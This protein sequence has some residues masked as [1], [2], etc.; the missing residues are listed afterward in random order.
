MSGPMMA[1]EA[2]TPWYAVANSSDV[3]SPALLVFPERVAHNVRKMIAIAGGPERLRPHVKTHKL[4]E[5]VRLK[6]GLGIQKF[7]CA[8]IAELEMLGD[9]GVE[10]A[11]LAYQPVGPNAKRFVEVVYAF[12]STRFAAVVDNISSARD[13][14]MIARARNLTVELLLDVDCG[15]QRTGIPPGREAFELY[16]F[17]SSTAGI[18][19][20]GLHAYDGHIHDAEPALRFASASR[21]W[22]L[23]ETLRSELLNAGFQV[24]RVVAGGSPTFPFHAS[25]PCTECSPG[26]TVLWDAGSLAG[27]PD[28]DFL[29]AAV[30]LARVASRPGANRLCLDLGTKS[31]ASEMPAPRVRLLG[32]EDAE[33]VMHNEEHLVIET[34]EAARYAPGDVIY[35][36]P[37]HV[38]P[39]VAL[40]DHVH[41]V[42]YN[43][44]DI[45][46]H[47]MARRRVISI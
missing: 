4:P 14:A 2:A 42:R 9:T 18:C 23:T 38:C 41:V 43:R 7:K 46:W 15:M 8:T 19:A 37:W 26:T 5:L 45:R 16:H 3:P 11:L 33:M 24:P 34:R 17:L 22:A 32:L 27:L 20:G 6:R 21:A 12:P 25:T 47:V 1:A 29:S 28:M 36:I 10:D 30:M 35:G 39:T 44:V 40:H 31:I 13:I